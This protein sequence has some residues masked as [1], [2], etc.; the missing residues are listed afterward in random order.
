[1][2]FLTK[3]SLTFRQFFISDIT[4]WVC[5]DATHAQTNVTF[6]VKHRT[7]I[8]FSLHRILNSH[9]ELTSCCTLPSNPPS[10]IIRWAFTDTLLDTCWRTSA[11]KRTT[12]SL[13]AACQATK[14][15]SQDSL[16]PH[17]LHLLH[18]FQPSAFKDTKKTPYTI[19]S[20][21]QKNNNTAS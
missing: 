17:Q 14:C 11:W 5:C 12:V 16:S 7:P 10:V 1:M 18:T 19:R 6:K 15:S 8:I 21:R 4:F 13:H 2:Y 9:M 3:F 20:K